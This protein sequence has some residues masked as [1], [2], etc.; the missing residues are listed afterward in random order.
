MIINIQQTL[1]NRIIVITTQAPSNAH[2]T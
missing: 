2:L 1:T